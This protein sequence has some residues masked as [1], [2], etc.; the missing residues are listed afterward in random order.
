MRWGEQGA[1]CRVSRRRPE[2]HP[3]SRKL[4]L[5]RCWALETKAR[6]AAVAVRAPPSRPA[7][8]HSLANCVQSISADLACRNKSEGGQMNGAEGKQGKPAHDRALP[9]T[10]HAVASSCTHLARGAPGNRAQAEAGKRKEG[11]P[12]AVPALDVLRTQA[13]PNR[14]L[15]GRRGPR[16]RRRA[17]P[18]RGAAVRH[19]ARCAAA[20]LAHA[21]C[22][23]GAGA[24]CG[25]VPR[26][27]FCTSS[28]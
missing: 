18:A 12:Q 22:R 11:L 28:I 21:G 24:C 13:L 19:A 6:S 15:R 14:S 9:A 26:V 4:P 10:E 25:A 23:A 8:R 17:R 20:A 2:G 7:S 3:G 1:A 16:R 5:T 27:C